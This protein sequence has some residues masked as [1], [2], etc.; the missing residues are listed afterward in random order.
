MRSALAEGIILNLK[1]LRKILGRIILF[2]ILILCESYLQKSHSS[3]SPLLILTTVTLDNFL[4]KS[5]G[6]RDN[7]AKIKSDG[8]SRLGLK[9]V[10]VKLLLPELDAVEY[11]NDRKNNV[12][13]AAYVRVSTRRQAKEGSSL[14][15]Q[16]EELRKL[17][18]SVGA[19]VVYWF[20]DAKSGTS[21]SGRKLSAI[22]RLAELGLINKLLVGGIDRLGRESCVLLSFIIT[23]RGLGVT[24]VTPIEELDV[25][26]CEDL[27]IAAVKLIKAEEE[28]EDRIRAALRSRIYNFK[29]KKWNMRIPFGY[30][31]TNDGWIEKLPEYSR[32]IKDLFEY[33]KLV[34]DY[35]KTANYINIKYGK[36]I[37]RKLNGESVKRLLCNPVY[38]GRPTCGGKRTRRFFNDIEVED[39]NLAV[40]DNEIFEEV[41]E[42]IAKKREK[43]ERKEKPVEQLVEAL[44]EDV[45]EI[46]D[47]LAFLCPRCGSPMTK[48]GQTYKCPKCNKQRRILKKSEAVKIAEWI[49]NREKVIR[50]FQEI[51]EKADNVNDIIEKF[52]RG[53]INMSLA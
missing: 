31:L 28:N 5:K 12:R 11:L 13:V 34:K 42:I 22:Q 50:A 45:F 18:I 2:W 48:N 52:R 47:G 25:K 27:I 35:G 16:Q 20:I 36:L 49:L 9:D 33:F 32:V 3:L 51:L 40:I 17:A 23:M 7:T 4:Q 37:H 39:P 46:F 21:F 15:A 38:I 24:T 30:R 43:Y 1:S 14:E 29:Q 53:D 41:R 44:G 6:K 26:R 10:A 19:D 8:K